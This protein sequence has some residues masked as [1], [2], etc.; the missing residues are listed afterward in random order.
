MT[1]YL[2]GELI[3]PILAG[4]ALFLALL[5][6]VDLVAGPGR[7]LLEARG[8]STTG[9]YLLLMAP[10]WL[11]LTLPMGIVLGTLTAY[12]RLAND[13][14]LLAI[15]SGGLS[16]WAVTW[17]GLALFALA[18]LL[19]FGLSDQVVPQTASQ[20]AELLL[21][22]HSKQGLSRALVSGLEVLPDG[23]ERL[24]CARTFSPEEGT[25]SGVFVNYFYEGRRQQQL[26]AEKAVWQEG[27]WKL[28]GVRRTTFDGHENLATELTAEHLYSASPLEPMS[29]PRELLKQRRPPRLLSRADI[30]ERLRT[31]P[32]RQSA[33]RL[34][35][36]YHQ[37]LA[38]PL[39]CLVLGALALQLGQMPGRSGPAFALAS[40][41]VIFFVYW[42]VSS[43]AGV[44]CE[45]G[46]LPA[47]VA[48]YGPDVVALAATVGV[49]GRRVRG[50]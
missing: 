7:I 40:S 45:A 21:E 17:P 37:R 50:R 1:R 38:M 11:V 23:R 26:Y 30:K 28:E 32:D 33:A 47:V 43:A 19:N 14:E 49:A 34:L 22:S 20:A 35:L 12:R 3:G 48:A 24:V 29:A 4:I 16:P 25:A 9:R 42:L 15:Q 31:H 27:G 13:N 6:S 10:S 36:V 5:M 8:A 41:M 2:L 46:R 44:L 18:A 39:A